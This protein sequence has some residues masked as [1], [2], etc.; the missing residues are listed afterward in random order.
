MSAELEAAPVTQSVRL[1]DY[2]PPDY[3]IDAVD[4]DISLDPHATR[5]VSRLSLRPNPAGTPG[6]PLVLNG[7]DL[8][9]VRASLDNRPKDARQIIWMHLPIPRHH[10]GHIDPELARANIA[11]HD[12]RT[13][14]LPSE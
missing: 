9:P 3:L 13:H 8:H 2:R 4:L 7:D 12:R 5:V 14:P 6:A 1:A 11:T 10:G